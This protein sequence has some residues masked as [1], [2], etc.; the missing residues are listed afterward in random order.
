[1]SLLTEAFL[2]ERY[3]SPRL[4]MI[5]LAEVLRYKSRSTIYNKINDGTFPIPTYKGENGGRYADARDVAEYLDR[6]RE[7]AKT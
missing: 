7:E 6:C 1:M 3:K 4:T 5:Q 2:L